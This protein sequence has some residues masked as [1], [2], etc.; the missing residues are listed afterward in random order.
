[1]FFFFP[2]GADRVLERPPIITRI[3]VLVNT[4]VFLAVLFFGRE[5]SS[6]LGLLPFYGNTAFG[7]PWRLITHQFMH[8]SFLH[9]LFNMVYLYYVGRVV[10]DRIGSLR[11]LLLYLLAGIFAALF[12]ITL[13]DW[14]IMERPM[15]GASGAI[16]GLMGVFCILMPWTDMKLF[17]AYC[18]IYRAGIGVCYCSALWF[19]GGYFLIS[20]VFWGVATTGQAGGRVAYWAHVGGFLAGALFAAYLYGFK[21]L[22]HSEAQIEAEKRETKRKSEWEQERPLREGFRDEPAV[23]E[24]PVT[25]VASLLYCIRTGDARRARAEYQRLL[26]VYP[27]M[28]L[29]RDVYVRLLELL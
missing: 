16:S 3:L 23:E 22:F 14:A 15:L 11:M 18:V 9:L 28:K 13:S 4:L 25:E 24:A 6:L 20:N 10:E 26:A 12:Q 17:Y 7:E 8:A 21:A 19:L 1:V 29:R 5:K 2:I 27:E